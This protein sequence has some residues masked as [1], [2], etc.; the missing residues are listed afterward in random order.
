MHSANAGTVTPMKC[1]ADGTTLLMSERQGIEIDYC[2]D[3]RGVWLDRGELDKIL[4]RARA[5]EEQD[6]PAAPAPAQPALV[7][8]PSVAPPAQPMQPPV[9]PPPAP[10]PAPGQDPRFDPRFEQRGYGNGG[11]GDR[12]YGDRGSDD[13]RYGQPRYD[14]RDRRGHDG[15]YDPRYRK[16]KRNDWLSDLFD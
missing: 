8:P 10:A 13:R 9:Q 6:P 2:P 1:P 4:D 5:E 7:T 12:G 14:D 3:C 11:Y 15:G 16:R